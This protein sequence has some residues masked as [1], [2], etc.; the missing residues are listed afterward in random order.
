MNQGHVAH[1]SLRWT[2]SQPW[3][4]PQTVRV[5]SKLE[6]GQQLLELAVCSTDPASDSMS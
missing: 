5:T 6:S 1:L 2:F 3:S 4:P